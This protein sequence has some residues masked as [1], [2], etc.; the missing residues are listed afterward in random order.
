MP[1]ATV[2]GVLVNPG[3]LASVAQARDAQAAART[4]GQQIY[5]MKP[6]GSERDIDAAFATLVQHQV[7]GIFL[8]SRAMRSS[9]ASAID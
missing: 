5:I 1:T 8:L 6:P 2:I 3:S 9:P 7:G 4:L